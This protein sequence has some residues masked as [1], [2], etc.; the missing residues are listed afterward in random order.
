MEIDC[1]AAMQTDAVLDR[2]RIWRYIPHVIMVF[3]FNVVVINREA[4]GKV[5]ILFSGLRSQHISC[6][7]LVDR[8]QPAS[9]GPSY[10]NKAQTI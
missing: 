6:T 8:W 10:L 7:I 2:F 4:H 5:P 1:C 9:Y 3:K